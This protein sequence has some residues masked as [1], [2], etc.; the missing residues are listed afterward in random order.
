MGKS[1]LRV[2]KEV[3]VRPLQVDLFVGKG[4]T[5]NL[6]QERIFVLVLGGSCLDHFARLLIMLFLVGKHKVIDLP[7][8]AEGL[9]KEY[10]LLL[11]RV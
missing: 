10:L 9:G 4:E 3:P 8:T 7:A 6:T 11:G 2:T 1:D 5:I